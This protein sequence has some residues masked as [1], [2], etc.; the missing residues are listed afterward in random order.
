VFS[1]KAEAIPTFA[2][3]YD[4]NCTACHTAPPVLNTFGQRFLKNGYQ[5]PGTQDS[6]F[7][8]KKKLGDVTLDDVGNCLAFRLVGNAVR[9]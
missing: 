4:V 8:G 6:G 2:G 9:N 3:K 7:T 5:L 1:N